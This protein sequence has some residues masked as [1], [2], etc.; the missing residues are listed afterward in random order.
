M[1]GI[2]NDEKKSATA[3]LIM[4]C[5]SIEVSFVYVLLCGIYS[6]ETQDD[7]SDNVHTHCLGL[8]IRIMSYSS[9]NAAVLPIYYER[10]KANITQNHILGKEKRGDVISEDSLY[11][12]CTMMRVHSKV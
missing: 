11:W 1:S 3:D 9:I 7:D 5:V 2:F 10:N 6:C 12:Y 4:A 8:L